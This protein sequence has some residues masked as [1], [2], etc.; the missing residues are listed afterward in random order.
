MI[1]SIHN[2]KVQQVRALLSR[3]KARRENN[4]FVVEGVRLVEETLHSGWKTSQVLYSAGLSQR[5]VSLV[6]TFRLSGAP[7]E[8]V[9]PHVMETISGTENAQGILA[10]VQI[11]RLPLPADMSF[12]L[13]LESVR[14]PGNLGT[15]LRTAYAAGVQA[16]FLTPGSV[17]PYSPKVVRSSMGAVFHLPLVELTWPEIGEHLEKAGLLVVVA[18]AREGVVYSQANLRDPIA[19]VLGGEAEGASPAARQMAGITVYIP[20]PGG[21]ESLNVS[22]TAAILLFEVLRQ[23]GSTL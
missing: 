9:A 10:I 17:D 18:A 2:P 11:N 22:A 19:I 5:G 15:I 14:D 1:T 13:V 16:V 12:A 7:V 4:A 6:D 3:P 21:S 23:R 20:M 8:E